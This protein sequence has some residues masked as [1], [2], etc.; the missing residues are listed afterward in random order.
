MS[1]KIE[2]FDL[3][4]NGKQCSEGYYALGPNGQLVLIPPT[5][6]M[7]DGWRYATQKEIDAG[8][9]RVATLEEIAI[10]KDDTAELAVEAVAIDPPYR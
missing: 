9:V 3:D 8:R 7:I 5:G 10:P 4:C 2:R 6:G 1:S